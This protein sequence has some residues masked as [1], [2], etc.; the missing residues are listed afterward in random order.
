MLVS[1]L[2]S[3]ESCDSNDIE[4]GEEEGHEIDPVGTDKEFRVREGPADL[5]VSLEG[6]H[7]EEDNSDAGGSGVRKSVR[8]HEKFGDRTYDLWRLLSLCKRREKRGVEEPQRNSSVQCHDTKI[9]FPRLHDFELEQCFR[10]VYFW[11]GLA[12]RI[13]IGKQDSSKSLLDFT[14]FVPKIFDPLVKP[15][16]PVEKA[17]RSW[18]QS[19]SDLICV[20]LLG[21]YS[22]KERQP[23]HRSETRH[24][25]LLR[26]I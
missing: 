9:D 10:R 17:P 5:I 13:F 1:P 26:D 22:F 19:R 14:Q 18:L 8:H 15:I 25:S 7:M 24:N 21:S 16:N 2:R 23:H 12:F 4:K 11:D 20:T 6:E 3:G